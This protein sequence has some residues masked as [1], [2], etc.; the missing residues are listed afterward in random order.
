MKVW[1]VG[2]KTSRQLD[3]PSGPYTRRGV[4]REQSEL[5]DGMGWSHGD[6]EHPS[7]S[8]DPALGGIALHER[9]GFDSREALNKWFDGWLVQLDM[10]DF[11]VWAYEVPDSA[12][13]VGKHGQVVFSTTDATELGHEPFRREQLDLWEA[14]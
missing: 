8:F 1:R 6:D 12:A 4:P 14:A 5:L 2:H 7:P 13:R 9:C 11:V 3:F 10:A